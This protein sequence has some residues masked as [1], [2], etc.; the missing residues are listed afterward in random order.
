MIAVETIH[1][2]NALSFLELISESIE[3]F[4][5]RIKPLLTESG[6]KAVDLATQ[7]KDEKL[8][9]VGVLL[10][11]I[12]PEMEEN[13]SLVE[14]EEEI[15]ARIGDDAYVAEM[16]A[17]DEQKRI[18][19]AMAK[20]ARTGLREGVK[21]LTATATELVC[22]MDVSLKS[23]REDVSS[24]HEERKKEI[25]MTTARIGELRKQEEEQMER[26]LQASERALQTRDSL[27]SLQGRL[28]AALEKVDGLKW[29][30]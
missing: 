12:R 21:T 10:Y 6:Q 4:F 14:V 26:A 29:T 1:R 8:A 24:F 30:V 28:G 15:L 27:V 20:G 2:A 11:A 16:E 17:L 5:E 13:E 22:G 25:A 3:E 9:L 7:E 23:L 19:E 18:I